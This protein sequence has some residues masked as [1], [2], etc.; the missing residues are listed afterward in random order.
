MRK[1]KSEGLT[2]QERQKQKSRESILQAARTVLAEKSYTAMTIEDVLARSNVS[3]AT[4]YKYFDSKFA[5][6]RELHREFAPRL[7]AIYDALLTYDDPTE[8]ELVD[9]VMQ[10][11]E[12]YRENRDLIVTFAHMLATEPAFHPIM[13]DIIRETELR[14]AK[15][16]PAFRLPASGAPE[17][18]RAH[19][20]SRLLLRQLNDFCYEV[21]IF[22]WPIDIT[23]GCRIM[24]GYFRAF[25]DRYRLKGAALDRV[26]R[27]P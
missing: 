22:D 16:I 17:A 10:V 15:R 8:A 14:W 18:M 25:F 13:I 26:S 9:W 19:I 11:V 24:A 21:A 6:G 4:F 20:E 3:R 23:E 7:T 5:I 12:L 1:L 27:S 2:L